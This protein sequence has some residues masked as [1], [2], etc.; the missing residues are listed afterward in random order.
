MCQ[1][2]ICQMCGGAQ[3]SRGLL[4][5]LDLNDFFGDLDVELLICLIPLGSTENMRH[6]VIEV[7][8]AKHFYLHIR[9][10]GR[11]K[12]PAGGLGVLLGVSGSSQ[13]ALGVLLSMSF[14]QRGGIGA[15]HVPHQ[16]MTTPSR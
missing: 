11:K 1:G 5:L 16:H 15:R 7:V 14:P 6:R 12:P 4:N 2:D 10:T 13:R 9:L 8:G 3:K